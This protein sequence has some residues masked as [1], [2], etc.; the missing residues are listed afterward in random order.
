M[1]SRW[2]ESR[3]RAPNVA[4]RRSYRTTS[5]NKELLSGLKQFGFERPDF[6][7]QPS[8]SSGIKPEPRGWLFMLIL[9]DRG[10]AR[11]SNAL[12]LLEAE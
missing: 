2:G 8:M 7:L 12:R 5:A 10:Q 6:K 3:Y 4:L 1:C 9:P 11:Y